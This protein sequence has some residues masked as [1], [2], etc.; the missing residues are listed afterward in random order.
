MRRWS[1]GSSPHG[2]AGTAEMTASLMAPFDFIAPRVFLTPVEYTS[3]WARDA[4]TPNAEM[5]A[6]APSS[7]HVSVSR[8]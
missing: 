6:F 8:S 5:T 3:V 1:V 2:P 7:A 4:P